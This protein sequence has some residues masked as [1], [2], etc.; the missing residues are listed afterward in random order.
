MIFE[1]RECSR[2]PLPEVRRG[3]EPSGFGAAFEFFCD[4]AGNTGAEI[5]NHAAQG[6]RAATE[7]RCVVLGDGL[8]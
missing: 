5:R 1:Q 3:V 4:S 8:A 2:K 6:V 7:P